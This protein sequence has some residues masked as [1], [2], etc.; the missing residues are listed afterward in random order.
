MKNRI[1][2]YPAS[3]SNNQSSQTV[4]EGLRGAA[5]SRIGDRICQ[6]RKFVQV[7]PMTSLGAALGMGIFL[8]W[9]IKRK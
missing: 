2:N 1:L 3:T 8:G 9:V 7:H 4:F 5:Q 6:I